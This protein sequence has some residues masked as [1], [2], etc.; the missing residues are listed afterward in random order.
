MDGA[1]EGG[2]TGLRPTELRDTAES[3]RALLGRADHPPRMSTAP[4]PPANLKRKSRKGQTSSLLPGCRLEQS[5]RATAG[6]E[7]PGCR[8]VGHHRRL[9]RS[10]QNG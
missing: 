9:P 1:A 5:P 7:L 4:E 3:Q 6:S 8:K 10:P 2:C